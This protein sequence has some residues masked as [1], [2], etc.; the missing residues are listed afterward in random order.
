MGAA[1]FDADFLLAENAI[2]PTKFDEPFDPAVGVAMAAYG[3]LSAGP[4]V[5][6]I[7]VAAIDDDME[8]SM[9]IDPAF[10]NGFLGSK[11]VLG[12]KLA[13]LTA[14]GT[15]EAIMG[16]TGPDIPGGDPLTP[17]LEL[18]FVPEPTSLALLGIA[19]LMVLARRHR[20]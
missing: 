2:G 20:A 19:S 17:T 10:L 12:G 3:N 16:F 1:I 11:V 5:G 6:S 7:A 4:M 15:P 9:A 13:G 14:A 18:T 8:L